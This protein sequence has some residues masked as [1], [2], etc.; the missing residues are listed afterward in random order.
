MHFFRL[1]LCATLLV[2]TTVAR[3]ADS[4]WQCEEPRWIDE[5][6]LEGGIFYASVIGDCTVQLRKGDATFAEL[7]AVFRNEVE[8]SGKYVLHSG[9]SAAEKNGMAGFRY[10]LTDPLR[11]EGSPLKIRQNMFMGTD[12]KS[13]FLYETSSTGIEGSGKAA[14]LRHVEFR[15]ALERPSE[16][17]AFRI[18]F[19]NAVEVQR[20]W[21]AFNFVFLPIGKS[22]T[23]EKFTLARDKLLQHF[24]PLL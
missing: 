13:R 18:R 19:Q 2:A 1:A 24:A 12:G 9:P 8:K 5:P 17:A 16:G 21:F 4:R 7:L 22:I 10:D 14:Y 3:A 23:L 11:D 20:P 15:S 6:F